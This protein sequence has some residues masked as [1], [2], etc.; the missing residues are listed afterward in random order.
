MYSI[1][2][3]SLCLVLMIIYNTLVLVKN[4]EVPI[5]LSSTAYI[6]G[7]GGPGN[8][9]FTLYC[10]CTGITL[11]PPLLMNTPDGFE[12]LSFLICLGFLFS[13]FSPKYKDRSSL[14]RPVHYWAAYISFAA[15]LILGFI[16]LGWKWVLAYGIVF[17]GFCLWK[18]KCYTYFGE[19]LSLITL[20]IWIL[21]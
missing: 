4:K 10:V 2:S 13:G 3:I 12:V 11:L 20:C 18:P 1:I 5:S 8:Y 15:F 21:L 7:S 14:D 6:L 19:I 9:L 17:G 16:C